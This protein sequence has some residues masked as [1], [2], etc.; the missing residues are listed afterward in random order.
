MYVGDEL[1]DC[2]HDSA[3]LSRHDKIVL[4]RKNSLNS[5]SNQ[6]NKNPDLIKN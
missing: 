3:G 1:G 5:S 4:G 6:V 2:L